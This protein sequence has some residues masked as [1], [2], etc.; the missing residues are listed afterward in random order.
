MKVVI[1]AAGKGTRMLPLTK[2]I[3]KV[4]VEVNGKPFLYYVLKSL[5]KAGYKEF[6]IIVGYKKERI[7]SFLK[8]YK[9]KAKLIDQPQQLGT[10]HAVLQAKEWVGK[11]DFIVCSGDNLYDIN[12]LKK[13]KRKDKFNY[14]LGLEVEEW[15]KYGILLVENGFLKEIK[16]K[17]KQFVGNLINTGL[18]KLKPEIFS[19]LAKLKHSSRGEI[20]LTD[21][22]NVLAKNN[23]VK[24]IE[25][26]LWV[27]L[28]CKEDILRVSHFLEDNWEE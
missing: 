14:L 13:I 10:G 1:M 28:S 6:G 8:K 16:E 17:P 26:E 24:V 11:E 12:D 23:K 4:L 27:D 5:K 7:E 3:P 20:E 25:G 22:L 21:A 19:I 18:Y 15:Q 2:T 9:F